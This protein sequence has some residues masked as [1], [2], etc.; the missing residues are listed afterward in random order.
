MIFTTFELST[1][2]ITV[3]EAEHDS[4]R[5]QPTETNISVAY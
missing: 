2:Q 1:A 5:V 3:L 4:G